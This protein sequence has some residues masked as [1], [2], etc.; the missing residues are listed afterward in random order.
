MRSRLLPAGR[1]VH[2]V[3]PRLPAADVS[4][5]L[6]GATSSSWLGDLSSRGMA[7]SSIERSTSFTCIYNSLSFHRSWPCRFRHAGREQGGEGFAKHCAK[8]AIGERKSIGVTSN[9]PAFLGNRI[10]SI[11]IDPSHKQKQQTINNIVELLCVRSQS[12]VE[13]NGFSKC[14]CRVASRMCARARCCRTMHF[15]A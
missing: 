15:E 1:D 3:L 11:L 4:Y 7:L 10:L 9:P 8:R 5:Q 12:I 6:R 14:T 13:N 2:I